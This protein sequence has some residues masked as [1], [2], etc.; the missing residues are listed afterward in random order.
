MQQGVPPVSPISLPFL[1]ILRSCHKGAFSSDH[2]FASDVTYHGGHLALERIDKN[3]HDGLTGGAPGTCGSNVQVR[4][5]M[6]RNIMHKRK[7]C[8]KLDGSKPI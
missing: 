4:L 8:L 3:A 5:Q 2:L 1:C 7:E 6:D